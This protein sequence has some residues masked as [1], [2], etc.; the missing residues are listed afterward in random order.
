MEKKLVTTKKGVQVR[1][2]DA[3]LKMAEKHFGLSRHSPTAKEVPIELLKMPKI[4]ITKAVRVEPVKAVE[5]PKEVPKEVLV[6]E[7]PVK[8]S[9]TRKKK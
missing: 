4:D 5:I 9:V 2:N 3:A 8:K 7:I 1:M 6:D